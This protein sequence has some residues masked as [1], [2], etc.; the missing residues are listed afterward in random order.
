MTFR[1][2][3]ISHLSELPTT[4]LQKFSLL[5]DEKCILLAPLDEAKGRKQILE[6]Y[7]QMR[8]DFR[9][10]TFYVRDYIQNDEKACVTWDGEV[11]K[12]KRKIQIKGVSFA[13]ISKTDLIQSQVDYWNI[14]L[15][16]SWMKFA[17]SKLF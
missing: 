2:R 3:L 16:S 13:S 4:D 11:I 15:R 1:E 9:F 6:Y 10:E 12:G 5:Y 8:K 17:I 7:Q 14:D